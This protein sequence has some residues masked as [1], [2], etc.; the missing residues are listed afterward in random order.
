MTR[1]KWVVVV[2]LAAGVLAAQ[3]SMAV[4]WGEPL[5]GVLFVFF[6]IPLVLALLAGMGMERWIG[7]R[8][9]GTDQVAPRSRP[10]VT[11]V[12]G[13]GMLALVALCAWFAVNAGPAWATSQEG[14]RVCPGSPLTPGD[15]DCTPGTEAVYV[16]GLAALA[17]GGWT[18][19]AL[20]LR[21]V[22]IPWAAIALVVVV[23]VVLLVA[24]VAGMPDG[25]PAPD[26]P[27]AP[28]GNDA[29]QAW[30]FTRVLDELH[31]AW[32]LLTLAVALLAPLV[33]SRWDR[34]V[35][36]PVPAALV[37]VLNVAVAGLVTLA[38]AAV[39]LL[40]YFMEG[41]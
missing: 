24:A 41:P 6:Q 33:W 15:Y 10:L 8:A 35:Q 12:A 1:T 7:R 38:S 22:R 31:S 9:V 34:G 23:G 39:P 30:A 40:S 36:P 11:L 29:F 2:L 19:S 27:G 5:V 17:L 28:R 21:R 32:A 13:L 14:N 4:R 37:G 26:L 18:M 3:G 25:Y 20:R 16:T